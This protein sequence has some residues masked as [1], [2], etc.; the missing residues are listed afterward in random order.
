LSNHDAALAVFSNYCLARIFSIRYTGISSV[1]R[2]VS[3]SP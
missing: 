3:E 1:V 2:Y